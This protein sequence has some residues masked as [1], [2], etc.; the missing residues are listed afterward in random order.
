MRR[1]AAAANRTGL[2]I[3][4]LIAMALGLA[5][6]A[7]G[8]GLT[9]SIDPALEAGA[10]LGPVASVLALPYSALIAVI[11]ALILA[12]IGL[13]WLSAQVPRKDFAKP[14][15]MQA[16]SRTGLTT[17]NAEVIAEAV[18][19]DLESADGVSDAQV[20]LR[21]TA[22]RPELLIHVAAD[23]RADIDAIIADTAQRAAGNASLAL[24]APLSAVALEIAIA[25]TR[26]RRQRTVNIQ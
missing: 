12:V 26:S 21:G 4:G 7:I 15:R 19:A 22:R 6:L 14:F 25:R 23:E 17:V 1:T 3:L 9:A 8:F 18:A 20:I 2:I 11:A 10:D 16:D 5:V 24:G 13:R